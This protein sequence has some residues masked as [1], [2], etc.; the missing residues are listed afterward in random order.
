MSAAMSM[1][2]GL[3]CI[4]EC[5]LFMMNWVGGYGSHKG[6]GL[7]EWQL[8]CHTEGVLLDLGIS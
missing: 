4:M 5:F 2:D 1:S 6:T 7:L 3:Y 8:G